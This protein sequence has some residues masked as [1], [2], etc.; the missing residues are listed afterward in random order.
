MEMRNGAFLIRHLAHPKCNSPNDHFKSELR[1]SHVL[2]G[3]EACS[4][5]SLF[6]NQETAEEIKLLPSEQTVELLAKSQRNCESFRSAAH[7]EMHN[8]ISGVM[9][10]SMLFKNLVFFL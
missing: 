2:S 1:N 5:S 4:A 6:Y 10:L 3:F 7:R 8:I 9:K